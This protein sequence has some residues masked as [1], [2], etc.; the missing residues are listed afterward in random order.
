MWMVDGKALEDSSPYVL[1]A[2]TRTDTREHNDEAAHSPALHL[3]SIVEQP[4][5]HK[6]TYRAHQS[7]VHFQLAV[8]Q[9]V[10]VC[11]ASYQQ[12]IFRNVDHAII[13]DAGASKIQS[14]FGHWSIRTF[15]FASNHEKIIRARE[16]DVALLRYSSITQHTQHP[17]TAT[18]KRIYEL[19]SCIIRI[20]VRYRTGHS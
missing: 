15:C 3:S 6:H 7:S 9:A 5:E 12:R 1:R 8:L 14:R 19:R 18:A 17:Q 16:N 20:V 13:V 10:V 2:H 4:H 11:C